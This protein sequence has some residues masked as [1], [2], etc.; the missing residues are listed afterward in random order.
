M[1][2]QVYEKSVADILEAASDPGAVT[3]PER[4]ARFS[5][6]AEDNA[7][8]L[9]ELRS[10]LLTAAAGWSLERAE[11]TGDREAADRHA[12][13]ELLMVAAFLVAIMKKKAGEP[14]SPGRFALVSH[15]I[16]TNI[17]A[18]P[19][20]DLPILEITDE[21]RAAWEDSNDAA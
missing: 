2:N 9:R 16:A 13:D 6:F 17:A 10:F 21:D 11:A 4:F 7:E 20:D 12:A 19:I 18:I 5:K 8:S 3:D 14:F 15:L 1:V